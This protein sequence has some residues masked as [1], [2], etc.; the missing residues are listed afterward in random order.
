MKRFLPLIALVIAGFSTALAQKSKV[1]SFRKAYQKN[2]QDSTLALLLAERSS[3][4][5][6]TADVDSGMI[7]ARQA[8]NISR[9]IGFKKGEVRAKA[10]MAVFL[11][12]SGDLPGSLK[13]TFETLPEAIQIKEMRVVASCYNTRGLTYSTLKDRKKSL[14]NYYSFL[15][16]AEKYHFTPLYTVALNNIAREYLDM[17]QLDSAAWFNQ[18]AYDVSIKK[19]L[20]KNIG[21]PIRNF[22]II[23]FKKGDM[24]GA[25]AWYK[26]SLS[27]SST[28][29][30][31]Y[32]QSED[33]RRIAEA[34]QK[35]GK[36]DSV[37][38]YAKKGFEEAKM[39][40]NPDQVQRATTLL[41]DQYKLKGDFKNAFYF[42]QVTQAAKDSLFSQQKTLQV[43]NLAY[44]E[45][46]RKQEA[47][48][49]E[50]A[51]QNRVRFYM[52]LGVIGVFVLIAAILLFANSQRKKANVLL[53]QQNDQ[54][55]AQRKDLEK[56][57]AD[58]RNTQRQLIQS[59]KMASLGELTAG[60]AHEI[61]NP[62]NFVN[63]FSEVNME[64]I[65]EMEL[66]FNKGEVGEMRPLISD[67][68]ANQQKISQHGKRADFIV[69]GMLQHSR[70][71]TGEKQVT[72]I[73]ILADEFFKL[74]FHGLRAK[75]KSFN[76]EMVTHFDPQLPNVNI[77][78]QDIGRVLLN[79]FNNAFYAVNQKAK[80]AA[81]GYK[82]EVSVSTS[83]ENKNVVIKVKDNGN[84]IPDAIKD[85]IMQP[86]F[87]T[88]PTGEG[89]G[90][91]LSLSYDII[92]GHGGSI[93]INSKEGEGSEFIIQLPINS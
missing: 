45:E 50:I 75:D 40:R 1:D 28:H 44:N 20:M 86:F 26:K 31:H 67:I 19:K 61:Q 87:T 34:Y 48:A 64:L 17:D 92:K 8:L 57:I 90:L 4:D 51:Y 21:Y 25:I 53:K 18:K 76:A 56:T 71:S 63:N 27:D 12:I 33:F 47:H 36:S 39:D 68:K 43:Q 55:E 38:A 79:L 16:I 46:Q 2:K 29:G 49:A 70:A 11:N 78:Q 60:I 69:K 3:S 62:L 23:R 35:L 88:K 14:D 42:Q 85:K 74:S 93:N 41:T 80:S 24:A 72:N 91:G 15:H 59:E 13:I 32:L 58:L 5:F 66:E 83:T 9:R 7:C 54:I 82:P 30:N 84:G 37:I 89:T 22:G 73:N 81:A 77:V 6:L 65:E 10:A 52:L